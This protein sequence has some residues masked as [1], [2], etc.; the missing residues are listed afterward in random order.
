MTAVKC[1]A[2]R[3]TERQ[4]ELTLPPT[5]TQAYPPLPLDELTAAIAGFPTSSMPEKEELITRL[6]GMHPIVNLEWGQGWRY[7]RARLLDPTE[8]PTTV[9]DVIWR[10]GTPAKL[11]RAN[12]QGFQ[13]L[14]LADRADTA[15]REVKATNNLVALAEFE[16][17]PGRSVR[18]IPIGELAQI[19]RTGRGYLSGDSSSILTNIL[20]ACAL[21]EAKSMLI[22][23]D[24]LLECLTNTNDDYMLSSCVARSV[25][26]KLPFATVVAYPSRRQSGAI[27]LAVRVERFWDNWGISTVRRGRA[28]HLAQGYYRF[29]EIRHVNGITVAGSLQ[30]GTDIDVE[31][32]V[33][34][35]GPLWT[36]STAS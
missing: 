20:N 11:G 36:P 10:K 7:R 29:N 9:D 28:L 14:Y 12:P 2:A 32:S 16:I 6:V 1:C 5:L 8:V 17:L 13:V 3:R 27:N 33:T 4:K 19:Q 15:F 22:T 31:N 35:L 25:F 18:I 24:F 34:L 23:D 26:D 21:D 30:W